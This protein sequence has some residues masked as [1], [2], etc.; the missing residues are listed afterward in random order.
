[1]TPSLAGYTFS[2]TS[3]AVTVN[4]ANVTVLQFHS[5]A[6]LRRTSV[7]PRKGSPGY[8]RENK[9]RNIFVI[10]RLLAILIVAYV[11]WDNTGERLCFTIPPVILIRAQWLPSDGAPIAL[12]S[13]T[14]QTRMEVPTK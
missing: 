6:Y 13:F 2:P 4:G 8:V 9:Q 7:Y 1:M 5:D 3:L 14:C 12:K 11:L 10:I